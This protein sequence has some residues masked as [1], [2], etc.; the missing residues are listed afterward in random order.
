MTTP[1]ELP[2]NIYPEPKYGPLGKEH[3]HYAVRP[4]F[5]ANSESDLQSLVFI[6]GLVITLIVVGAVI[7]LVTG[8]GSQVYN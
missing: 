4:K 7:F 8:R 1:S 2:K 6:L 3:A 5:A